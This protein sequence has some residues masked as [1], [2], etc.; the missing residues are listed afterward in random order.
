MGRLLPVTPLIVVLA[1][2]LA[3]VARA[4]EETPPPRTVSVTGRGDVKAPPDLIRIA[5]A[6]ESTG[7]TA[8]A[9][10]ADN[11]T[12]AQRVSAAV[13]TLVGDAGRLVTTG[14]RLTPIYE[15]PDG[16]PR[17]PRPGLEAKIIG[18]RASNEVLVELRALPR[19]G[20]LI[21]AAIG[22]GANR[23]GS[24]SFDLADRTVA[25]R[26]AIADA[27]AEARAQAEAVAQS[28]GVRLARVRTASTVPEHVYLPMQRFGVEAAAMGAPPTPV[29]PGD[30]TVSASVQVTYDLE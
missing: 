26:Q 2:G 9:A 29:E 28:L 25:L 30:V 27:G 15:P 23:V 22:A 19:A 4:H 7:A 10:A 20:E 6:V 21:D 12:R 5:F 18:Y 14:Y 17:R 8:A 1:G 3:S 24:L 16:E 13:G 11:R